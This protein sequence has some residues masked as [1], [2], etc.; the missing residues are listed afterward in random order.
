MFDF[1]ASCMLYLTRII[2]MCYVY[3]RE[4]VKRNAIKF[5]IHVNISISITTIQ[6]FEIIIQTNQQCITIYVAK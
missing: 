6:Y 2:T 5:V 1:L 4:N 3:T